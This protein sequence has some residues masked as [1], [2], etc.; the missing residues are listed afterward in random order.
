[1]S[2]SGD[3]SK[4]NT[5]PITARRKKN[6]DS[7][8]S[9]QEIGGGGGYWNHHRHPWQISSLGPCF[10]IPIRINSLLKCLMPRKNRTNCIVTIFMLIMV[11]IMFTKYIHM[12]N[13]NAEM[14]NEEE[15]LVVIRRQILAETNLKHVQAPGIW[16]N[17]RSDNYHGCIGRLT[18]ETRNRSAPTNGYILVQA[19]GGLNQMKMGV[20]ILV[21]QSCISDMVAIA[22]LM[23]A[24]LVLPTLDHKSFWTDPSDFKDIFDVKQ[25]MATLQ[26]DIEIVESLPPDVAGFLHTDSRLAN[27]GI[28][29]S[30]Q[31]LRCRTM[32]EALK[33]TKEINELGRKLDMLAFTGCTHGLSEKEADELKALRYSVKRWKVKKIKSRRNRQQGN[34]PLTPRES[35][36]FLQALGFPSSTKIYIVA[37]EIY[38]EHGLDDFKEKYPNVYTHSTLATEDELKPF[39]RFHN[40]L[41]ALDYTLALASDV[42]VYTYDGNM[43]KAIQGHRMFRGFQKTIYPD[44]RNFVR[45]L[46]ELDRRNLSWEDFSSEVKNLHANRTSRPRRRVGGV[47]PKHEENFYANPFPGCI[48]EN[49]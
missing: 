42:F 37:G 10:M 13:F 33:C 7:M 22:K 4:G 24:T 41:A 17:P 44:K 1:M 29:D 27:N 16:R 32:Y 15:D 23:H 9:L 35:A 20:S 38:G 49:R 8:E 30:I 34:C 31:K 2:S 28:P 6:V 26:D 12:I 43:A 46:D 45:M 25:F 39:K 5:L 36:I 18:S 11:T 21:I 14:A 47:K 19:N 48:C 3:T 40:Q